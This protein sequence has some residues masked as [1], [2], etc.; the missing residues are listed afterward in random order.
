LPVSEECERTLHVSGLPEEADDDD[1]YPIF[2]SERTGG[3]KIEQIHR[4]TATSAVITFH[5]DVG[6]A[7]DRLTC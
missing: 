2:E 3:G 6:K 5:D 1:I 7:V 4:L